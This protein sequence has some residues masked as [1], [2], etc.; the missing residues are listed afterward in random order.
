MNN[1]LKKIKKLYGEDMMH[2][3]RERCSTLLET[4]GLLL[5]TLTKFFYP[6]KFEVLL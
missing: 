2:F 6:N 1:E 4:D 3:V 5:E